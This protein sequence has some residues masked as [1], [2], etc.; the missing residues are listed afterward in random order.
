MGCPEHSEI[1]FFEIWMQFALYLTLFR[2]PRI[3]ALDSI[4]GRAG[5]PL[6][7]SR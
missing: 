7:F 6:H 1:I 5:V 2:F 3:D 4:R